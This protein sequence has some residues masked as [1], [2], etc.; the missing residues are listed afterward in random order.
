MEP[1]DRDF[2]VMYLAE[3]NRRD[4]LFDGA[5][6]RRDMYM[7]GEE[8]LAVLDHGVWKLTEAGMEHFALIP[9]EAKED[10]AFAKMLTDLMISA[11]E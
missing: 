4:D 11:D 5:S 9:D 7:L 1:Q 2:A 8:G 10:F 3:S 6:F